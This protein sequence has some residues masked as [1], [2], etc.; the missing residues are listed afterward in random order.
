MVYTSTSYRHIKPDIRD[1]YPVHCSIMLFWAAIRLVLQVVI[2]TIKPPHLRSTNGMVSGGNETI[3]HT[4]WLLSILICN[5]AKPQ[6]R[7][8]DRYASLC[9]KAADLNM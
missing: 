6:I 4:I 2:G 1:K 3:E 8:R 9:C 5:K 7:E